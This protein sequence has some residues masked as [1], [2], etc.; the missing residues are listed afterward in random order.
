MT[1]VFLHPLFPITSPC[2]FRGR[3]GLFSRLL[4]LLPGILCVDIRSCLTSWYPTIECTAITFPIDKHSFFSSLEHSFDS[5]VFLPTRL[6]Q[7]MYVKGSLNRLSASILYSLC[8]WFSSFHCCNGKHLC[9]IGCKSLFKC[10][11]LPRY[12]H[13]I[14]NVESMRCSF[15]TIDFGTECIIYVLTV[16]WFACICGL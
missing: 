2:T 7:L 3:R 10:T 9:P 15:S 11:F 8:W 12:A 4:L 13:L 16:C 1:V 14:P 6:H 5:V